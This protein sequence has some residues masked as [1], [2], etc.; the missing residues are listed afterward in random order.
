MMNYSHVNRVLAA[1][2]T[3]AVGDSEE[4]LVAEGAL[5]TEKRPKMMNYSGDPVVACEEALVA[6]GAL[7]SEA[8][9]DL[10]PI[11]R[12]TMVLERHQ[13]KLNKRKKLKWRTTR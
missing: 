7:F 10:V 9:G 6:E 1:E 12:E 4:I 3:E 13:K 2:E 11:Q 5:L 8:E